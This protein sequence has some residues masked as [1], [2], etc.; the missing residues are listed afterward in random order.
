MKRDIQQQL[1]FAFGQTEMLGNLFFAILAGEASGR[2]ARCAQMLRLELDLH[3]KLIAVER[4][5]VSLHGVARCDRLHRVLIERA[6]E[7]GAMISEP[8]FELI[9]DHATSFDNKRAN[10]PFVL[11]PACESA[12]LR[13]LHRRLGEKMKRA[14]IGRHVRSHFAPHMTLL[15]DHRVWGEYAIG[16][17]HVPVTDF[18]LVHSPTGQNRYVELA[19]WPLTG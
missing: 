18:V 2:I 17:I 10:K 16:P 11:R 8:A 6:L 1:S 13:S 7:V 12:G 3:S 15:Y 19:R 5:H 9:F 14:R 4:L